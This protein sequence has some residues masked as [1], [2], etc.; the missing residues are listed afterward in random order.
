MSFWNFLTFMWATTKFSIKSLTTSSVCTFILRISTII[1]DNPWWGQRI[2]KYFV[3]KLQNRK[4]SSFKYLKVFMQIVKV[5]KISKGSLDSIPSPSTSRKV[6]RFTWG[7]KA[8]HCW[9]LS[10]NV[11]KQKV[12]WHH[13][14][15]FYFI[16]SSKLSRQ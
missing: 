9:V 2:C 14:A 1:V 16:A 13:P 15:I 12:C 11:W 6:G 10:T 4:K 8:K 3:W 5:E 7:V